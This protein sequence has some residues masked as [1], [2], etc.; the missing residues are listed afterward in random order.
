MGKMT[1]WKN[2]KTNDYKYTDRVLDSFFHVSGTK[3][4]IHEYI[5]TYDE[6]G[7][8]L[9]GVKIQDVLF[10]E[11]R[12][13][14]YSK[15]ILEMMAI[16]EMSDD[17]FELSQFGFMSTDT[18]YVD[19]HLNKM[20]KQLGRKLSSGDVIEIIHIRDDL[21]EEHEGGV[22]NF[23]VVQEG[24]R[25][26]QGFNANWLPH[27]WRVRLKK[28]TDS[29]MYDDI[30]GDNNDFMSTLEKLEGVNDEVVREAEEDVPSEVSNIDYVYD[31]S[32]HGMVTPPKDFDI[33]EIEQA[34]TFPYEPEEGQYVIRVDYN[35]SQIF[36]YVEGMWKLIDMPDDIWTGFHQYTTSFVEN[37]RQWTDAET[38]ETIKE[39]GYIT[40]PLGIEDD[41]DDD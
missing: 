10:M 33:N 1:L 35:P 14:R 3:M 25:P 23:F 29:P 5:G 28:I 20:V 27:L 16:Y 31:A 17:D 34:T 6:K 19:F 15:D 30:L 36:Q 8:P 7:N 13:R 26:A 38:N 21:L 41:D 2:N 40:N 22:N 11:T 18:I 12:D 9:D 24:R 37:D 39:R 4:L 32:K